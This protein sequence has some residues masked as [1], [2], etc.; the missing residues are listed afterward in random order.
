MPWGEERSFDLSPTPAIEKQARQ[1]IEA[2]K[3]NNPQHEPSRVINLLAQYFRSIAETGEL[4]EELES[5]ILQNVID[6]EVFLTAL[7]FITETKLFSTIVVKLFSLASKQK[8]ENALRFFFMR[9]IRARGSGRILSHS[10]PNDELNLQTIQLNT[11][12][13]RHGLSIARVFACLHI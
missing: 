6:L 9:N 3:A 10:A 7:S 12:P 5:E 13:R 2:L 4:G 8:N 11:T 1:A